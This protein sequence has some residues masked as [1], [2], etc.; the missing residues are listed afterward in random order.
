MS[1]KAGVAK[2][3]LYHHFS[4][5]EDIVLAYLEAR[6]NK[7]LGSL[8][9]AGPSEV[10]HMFNLL[11]QKAANPEFRGCAFLLAVSEYPNAPAIVA[12]AQRHK[13]AIREHFLSFLSKSM[14]EREECATQIAMVYDGALAGLT[15][16]RDP[17]LIPIA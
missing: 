10:S 7:I 17:A 15:I 11:E 3:S 4:G 1:E 16:H 8:I 2:A 14:L 13:R 5:K 12:L 9:D 6:H